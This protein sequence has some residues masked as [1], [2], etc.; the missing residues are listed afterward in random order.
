MSCNCCNC[1]L[2]NGFYKCNINDYRVVDEND[3]LVKIISQHEITEDDGEINFKEKIKYCQTCNKIFRFPDTE[4]NYI[5]KC[6]DNHFESFE[7]NLNDNIIH[8]FK[9]ITCKYCNT[10]ILKKGYFMNTEMIQSEENLLKYSYPIDFTNTIHI[11]NEENNTKI[12]D[13]TINLTEINP[14]PETDIGKK[15][16]YCS[17]CNF[18][19]M[20]DLKE[21]YKE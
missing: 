2:I 20:N 6:G 3:N 17:D 13:I 7:N 10:N 16:L 19:I 4:E 15:I 11:Y 21:I 12:K 8:Q 1:S 18:F 9:N 5:F 14:I